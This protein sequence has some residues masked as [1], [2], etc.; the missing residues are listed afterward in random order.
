MLNKTSES[1]LEVVKTQS[2]SNGCVSEKGLKDLTENKS[3]AAA[4]AY[5]SSTSCG[6]EIANSAA[7]KRT[8]SCFDGNSGAGISATSCDNDAAEAAAKSNLVGASNG[9]AF[10]T[11]PDDSPPAKKAN[12][13]DF[14]SVIRRSHSITLSESEVD[15]KMKNSGKI[16]HDSIHGHMKIPA[17]AME[18]IDTPQFQRLRNIKQLGICNY[19]FPSGTHSR[20]EHS[21]GVGHLAQKFALELKLQRPDLVTEKDVHCVM[22]AG[23]CHDLGH[24]PFS[25]LWEGYVKSMNPDD[26][27]HHEDTSIQMLDRLIQDNNL[28]N[29]LLIDHNIEDVDI[30]FIKELI[31][32]PLDEKTGLPLRNVDALPKSCWPYRGRSEDKSFLYEIVANKISGIDVDK[33]DY[34]LRDD[35][36]LKIGHVFNYERF[37]AYAKIIK[38]GEP[39]RRHICLRDKEA[40][41]LREMYQDRARLHRFG[42]QHRVT[43]ILDTMLKDALKL[44][45]KHVRT[46]GAKGQ[47]YPLSKCHKDM[48]AYERLTDSV[49]EKILESECHEAI[50]VLR[51]IQ[52]RDLYRALET[53]SKSPDAAPET[54][55]LFRM[56]DEE[57]ADQVRACIDTQHSKGEPLQPKDFFV[58]RR[59]VTQGNEDP[60]GKVSFYFI[61]ENGNEMVTDPLSVDLRLPDIVLDKTIWICY[62]G[63][64]EKSM[65]EAVK[66]VAKWK[67][68]NNIKVN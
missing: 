16:F 9:S 4:C 66:V 1:E 45:D 28:E 6:G 23:L 36:A 31:A 60:T 21:L 57:I 53:I 7:F 67:A 26:D 43:K 51:R 48:L 3:K 64:D 47:T 27:W 54:E 58:I 14:A 59:V 49:F 18:F 22:L 5:Q 34:F 30:L 17:V 37:I 11:T 38:H 25:H 24:G 46:K 13:S 63:T 68:T 8:R 12:Y 50:T 32:G 61:G 29:R 55:Q 19:V 40:D 33:W 41:M 39:A 65:K 62:K 35:Y 56:K 10:T 44:A 42:Y 52:S 20:F 2:I 15:R